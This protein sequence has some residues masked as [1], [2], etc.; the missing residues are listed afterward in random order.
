[1]KRDL[2]SILDMEDDIEDVIA[3]AL[4]VKRDRYSKRSE[5]D[6]R[7][8]GLIFEKPSTRTRISLETAITQLGGHGIYLNP[9]DMQMGRGETVEDTA[10]VLSGF[11]DAITYRAFSHENVLKLARHSSVPVIN[12]LD[13]VEHPLQVLADFMTIAEKK[14]RTNNL[15][16]SYVGDGN[17][18]V[19]SLVLGCSLLGM[20]ISIG[21]P[22]EYRPNEKFIEK[23]KE[24]SRK[25]GSKIATTVDPREAVMDADIIYTDVWISMGEEKQRETKEKAFKPYQVN[26]DLVSGAKKDYIFMHCLP[27]HRGLEV[28]DEVADSINSVI[29]QEAENRLHSAKAAFLTLMS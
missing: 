29:F 17:N 15:K 9:N 24:I 11:L 2:I 12:A 14:G 6:G 23:A 21:T 19:N 16:F 28:T 26:Q 7:T 4:R 18:M 1:M 27:A 5:L 3:I 25:T 8:V 20:D 22:K 10:K 13:D